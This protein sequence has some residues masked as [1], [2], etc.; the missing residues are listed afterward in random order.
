MIRT[1]RLQPSGWACALI[2]MVIPFSGTSG[3]N[4]QSAVNLDT[5][6]TRS[7]VIHGANGLM[8]APASGTSGLQGAGQ[9]TSNLGGFNIVISPGAA[10]SA[11]LP[12]LNAFNRAAN[13]WAQ[14]IADPVTVTI[15]ADLAPLGAN[16]LG[17]T[18]SVVLVGSY[19]TLRNQMV[20]DAANE[21]DDGIVSSLPASMSFTLPTG[22]AVNGNVQVTKAN[23]KALGFTGLDAQFGTA[24]ANMTF[25]SN[26]SFDFDRSDGISPGTF[27][28]EGIA[29]HE[30]GH[31]LGFISDVDY[32]DSVMGQ[33]TTAQDV[34]PTTLDLFRFDVG[35]PNN[36]ATAAQFQTF[37]RGMV[38][39]NAES[40]DQINGGFGA[41][42]VPFATGVTQG[43]GRQASHWKDNLGL[44]I[45]DPTANPQEHLTITPNDLR[46]LDLIGWEIA[47]VPEASGLQLLAVAGVVAA[48]GR[49][50]RG[51]NEFGCPGIQ[52]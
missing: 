21:P 12:A 26:F 33:S 36:P 17:Q 41:T 9:I 22:F 5:G 20:A 13:D 24:D 40:F 18:S 8:A 4:A 32:V 49:R 7:P 23:A 52:A 35:G 28:F 25:S 39:G 42:E 14:F 34:E 43:D 15:N 37:P 31:A 38:P 3:A 2:A 6:F 11:N 1:I 30:I 51:R 47:P 16:I 44:G 27:D 10:L 19:S 45:M 48:I 29:A 50:F 46:A